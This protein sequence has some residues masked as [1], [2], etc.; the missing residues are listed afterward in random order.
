MTIK[1]TENVIYHTREC[2]IVHKEANPKAHFENFQRI[3][4]NGVGNPGAV[5]RLRCVVA[6]TQVCQLQH[7]LHLAEILILQIKIL[8][9]AVFS[10]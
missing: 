2:K 1:K 9:N 10:H 3:C 4:D 7:T 8:K 6:N 5:G